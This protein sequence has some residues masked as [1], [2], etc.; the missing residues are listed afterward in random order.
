MGLDREAVLRR[1]AE[2]GGLEGLDLSGQDMVG[3]DLSGFD[4]H[5]VILARAD[6]RKADLRGANLDYSS[7][8]LWCGSFQMKVDTRFVWQLIAHLGRL[9]TRH[10]SKK[11]KTA[12]KSIEPYFDEFCR[13]R[14]DV[15]R[16]ITG[17]GR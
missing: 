10:V 1:I 16:I 12:I 11:A 6:L 13:Y 9:N 2:E 4:L 8:P 14:D 17:A 15:E 3:I 5:G 7:F